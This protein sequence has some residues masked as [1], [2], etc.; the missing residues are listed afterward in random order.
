MI[1][2]EA[3]VD[4]VLDDAPVVLDRQRLGELAGHLGEAFQRELLEAFLIAATGDVA[5]L[6]ASASASGEG[7]ADL[8]RAAHGLRIA[9]QHVGAHALATAAMELETCARTL[10][11]LRGP[12][13]DMLD[14]YRALLVVDHELLRLRLAAEDWLRAPAAVC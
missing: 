4:Y 5:R 6:R 9:C 12:A 7:V 13:P 2:P 3:D 14:V 10:T 8:T 1:I 11:F